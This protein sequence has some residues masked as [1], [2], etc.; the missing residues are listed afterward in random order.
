MGARIL[1]PADYF[2]NPNNLYGVVKNQQVLYWDDNHLTVEGS[3]LLAPLFEQI[4]REP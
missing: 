4:F 1:D 3:M 2:L